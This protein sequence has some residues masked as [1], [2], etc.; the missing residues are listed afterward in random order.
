M[1]ALLHCLR[2]ALPP[3]TFHTDHKAIPDALSKGRRRCMAGKIPA[4]DLWNN[5]W[6]TAQGP[7]VALLGLVRSSGC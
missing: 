5:I 7:R 4:A 2:S 1:Q 3:M 6:E